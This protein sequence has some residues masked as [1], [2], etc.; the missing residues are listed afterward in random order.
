MSKFSR[1][2]IGRSGY[3]REGFAEVYDEHRPSP[4][5][6]VIDA[7]LFLAQTERPAL[8][9]DLGAGTGLSTRVWSERADEVIGVD[10]NP[11][12]IERAQLMTRASNVRFV[13][14]FAAE[15][16]LRAG[17][18]DIVTCS[19]SFHWMEPEPVLAEAA[20]LLRAG[21]VFAAYDYDVP[22]AIQ[23]D[24]DEAFRALLAIRDAVWER[25]DPSA[26]QRIW[27]KDRHFERIEAS[28]RFR[29]TRELVCHGWEEADAARV[30]GLA[31]S[32]GGAEKLFGAAA[33]EVS[34]AHECLV[35]SAKRILGER[36]WPMLLC[37]RIRAGIK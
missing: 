37:F 33:P 23:P 20:R 18:A 7:L 25:V 32:L 11:R 13:E 19:Q 21:G 22:P 1:E 26:G 15:T 14:G 8:V 4:A 3:E 12:M 10:A 17:R 28:G 2:L 27:P 31:R 35:E 36:K 30:A 6:A 9:V 16:G 5:A 24:V 29:I 34:E